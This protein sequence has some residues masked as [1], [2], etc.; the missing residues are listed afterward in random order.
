MSSSDPERRPPAPRRLQHF[1]GGRW[2]DSSGDERLS[3]VD[4]ATEEPLGSLEV[5]EGTGHFVH[6]EQAELVA[7]WVV[8][9]LS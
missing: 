8:E 4:P 3:V 6:I 2:V 7:G 1:I 9:F 5:M